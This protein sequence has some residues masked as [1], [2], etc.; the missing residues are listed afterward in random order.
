MGMR[1]SFHIRLGVAEDAGRLAVLAAQ[2]WLHT[3]ATDGISPEIAE[4]VLAHLTPEQYA[5]L[6]RDASTQV[7]VA[8][9]AHH[10]V[11]LAVVRFDTPCPDHPDLSAELQTLYVQEHFLGQGVGSLL[12]AAAEALAR[13]RANSRLW[14]TVNATNSRAIAFYDRKG[15]A[16]VGTAYFVLGTE[17][18]ENHVLAGPNV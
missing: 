18:Y 17:R 4:Y 7:L 8:L 11:G 15:Y 12:L 1:Q 9:H 10:V 5:Q 3:Y 16:K 13:S 2:V 6:L 14:L